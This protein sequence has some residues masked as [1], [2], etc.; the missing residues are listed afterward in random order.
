[1][2][3][4]EQRASYVTRW[5]PGATT[6]VVVAGG[7]GYGSAPNQL[8]TPT[9]IF[10]DTNGNLY[11]CD[12]DNNRIQKWAPGATSGNT[13]AGGNFGNAANQLANP[14]G[15]YVDV[16]GNIYITDYN[17]YRVQKW[18]P[19]ATSGIT[20]AG[21][22]FGTGGNQFNQP[23]G[24]SMDA[25]CN[26]Y[27]SDFFNNRVQ[28]F[29]STVSATITATQPGD[30][31]ASITTSSGS[32]VV[33]NTV[34]IQAPVTPQITIEADTIVICPGQA[35][36]FHATVDNAG[37]S[38]TFQWKKNG[39]NAGTN[40]NTFTSSNLINGDV[41][42]CVLSSTAPC[43]TQQT[44]NSNAIT[45]RVLSSH[46]TVDVGPDIKVCEGTP[47]VLNAGGP[48][49]NYIWQDGSDGTTFTAIKAGQYSVTV[50]DACGS[51]SDTVIVAID[52]N[53]KSFLPGDTVICK[54]ELLTI[55]AINPYQ[56]Y[57]WSNGG[58]SSGIR[59]QS[60]GVYWLEVTDQN[61]CKGRDS[62]FVTHI[63]CYNK[64]YIP[65]AF[66]PNGD[67]KN[68]YFKPIFDGR[69]K[70]FKFIVYNRWGQVV[71]M[72][73]DINKMWDGKESG[74][75]QPNGVFV[76]TCSY[77]FVNEEEKL[78]KGTVTIIH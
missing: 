55:A 26:L 16:A 2:Y 77:Q 25:N 39:I 48:Y 33:S 35:I 13:V 3:V 18:L 66:T 11:I 41:I 75:I 32:T 63:I 73:T 42:I 62:I 37:Q 68:D 67:G 54:S 69:L 34:T 64:L 12:T 24:I 49:T 29:S 57:L 52:A 78:E 17:N 60:Q 6:G 50:E 76:W 15:I 46:K 70:K 71:F 65:S 20:V 47:I 38:P 9:G 43:I 28:K 61:S 27:V 8:S 7:N 30:Y 21:G 56:N 1:M 4:S 14:L 10:V 45:I 59:V 22:S 5:A 51:S 19:G 23:A 36:S 58:V 44:V 31:T 53:P 72:S 40:S 74:Q